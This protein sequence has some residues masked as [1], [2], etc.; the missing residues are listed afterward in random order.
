MK[1]ELTPLARGLRR[2]QTKAETKLWHHLRNRNF[3]GLKFRRQV[4]RGPYVA[5]F[6]CDDAM[7]IVELDG[8]QHSENIAADQKRTAFLESLG[9][10]V[11]RFWNVDVMTNLAGVLEMLYAEVT[12]RRKTPSSAPF[13]AP[14]PQGEKDISAGITKTNDEK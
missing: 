14:S 2:R 6:L 7:L 3:D 9:Y 10:R 5:D 4:P 12:A 8:S 13:G 11:L 1:I